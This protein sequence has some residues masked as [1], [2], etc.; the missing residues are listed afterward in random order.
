MGTGRRRPRAAA[1]RRFPLAPQPRPRRINDSDRI[2]KDM[3]KGSSGQL[4]FDRSLFQEAN[5]A[6]SHLAAAPTLRLVCECLSDD[7]TAGIVVS[8][9]AYVQ[10]RSTCGYYFV[11]AG[12]EDPAHEDV[13][14]ETAGCV[15]V[16]PRSAPMLA[17]GSAPTLAR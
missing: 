15:I 17:A 2:D 12:H 11:A 1:A 7:C 8:R 4:S 13:I 5:D 10:A 16:R 3:T 6:I 14:A 9:E